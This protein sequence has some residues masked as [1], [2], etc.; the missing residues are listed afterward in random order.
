MQMI[1]GGGKVKIC[2]GNFSGG[3]CFPYIPVGKTLTKSTPGI[4]L[5]STL[6]SSGGRRGHAEFSAKVG[7]ISNLGGHN[8][9]KYLN[10]N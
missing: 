1:R 4:G 9:N 10:M 6:E 3:K 5:L 7:G 2:W 8:V